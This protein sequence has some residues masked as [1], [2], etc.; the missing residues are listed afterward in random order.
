MWVVV[1]VLWLGIGHR[2]A[3]RGFSPPA[4]AFFGVLA[5]LVLG[6]SLY[7][8]ANVRF[9]SMNRYVLLALPVFFAVGAITRR[10]PLALAV[11]MGAC[12]WHYWQADLCFWV[13]DAGNRTL[14]ICHEAH[15]IGR[16]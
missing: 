11:W 4:R 13:G 1:V 15:W 12:V 16:Y 10:R 5:A 8:S 7:G 14:R 6:L 3:M 2:D 9:A